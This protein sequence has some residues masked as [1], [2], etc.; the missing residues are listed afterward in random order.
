MATRTRTLRAFVGGLIF[1]L[2]IWSS[3]A[4]ASPLVTSA[5]PLR[6]A[7]AADLKFA[8]PQLISEFKAE[9]PKTDVEAVYGSSGN[10]YAQ[11]LANAPFDLF[12]SADRSYP[13]KLI[14]QGHSL[15]LKVF[16]YGSGQL[17]VWIPAK[18]KLDFQQ[19]G[20]KALLDPSIK[21]IS[22]ANPR[23]APYGRA[24]EEALHKA[25]VYDKLKS[26]LV[27]G[28][29]V[30]QA[31]QFVESGAADVGIIALSLALAPE[32]TNQGRFWLVPDQDYSKM[33]QAGV[34]L[35]SAQKTEASKFRDFV[36]GPK[37]HAILKKAGL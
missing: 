9:N 30:V 18:S 31:A 7:A 19:K 2:G 22:I 20:F 4:S 6:V 35:R 27:L 33:D 13:D 24:A 36:M 5:S 14:E 8:M 3:Q 29:N 23:F 1:A 25:S 26:K 15:D 21:K 37:G 34:I 10:F 16:V 32:M 28:D 12:F 17:V 11:I